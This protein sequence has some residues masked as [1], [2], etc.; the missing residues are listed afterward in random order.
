MMKV[1]AVKPFFDK[2]AGVTRLTGDSFAVTEERYKELA[3]SRFG[4]LVEVVDPKKKPT[5]KG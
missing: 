2:K 4:V 3:E 1:K 5:K